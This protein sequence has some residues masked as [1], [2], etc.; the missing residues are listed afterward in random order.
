MFRGDFMYSNWMNENYESLKDLQLNQL[1][2]PGTHDSGTYNLSK[3]KLAPDAEDSIKQIWNLRADGSFGIEDFIHDWAKC[4]NLKFYDQLN[5]GIRYFD[6]RVCWIDN[7]FHTCHSLVG[8]L[9][10]DIISN[11]N[12]FLSE[13]PKE[14]IVVK[15]GFESLSNQQQSEAKNMFNS[16]LDNLYIETSQELLNKTFSRLIELDNRAI[17]DYSNNFISVHWPN[18]DSNDDMLS[19]LKSL[20]WDVSNTTSLFELQLQLTPQPLMYVRSFIQKN[21][22]KLLPLMPTMIEHVILGSLLASLGITSLVSYVKY[23]KECL[24]VPEN[25]NDLANS[26]RSVINNFFNWYLKGQSVNN[27]PIR[28]I[29]NVMICDLFDSIPFVEIAIC[30]NKFRSPD[31]LIP[32]IKQYLDKIK[33]KEA[34][35]Y[36]P[37]EAFK[38]SFQ[39]TLDAILASFALGKFSIIEL[40]GILKEAFNYKVNEMATILFGNG[41]KCEEVANALFSVYGVSW[42]DLAGY[43]YDAGYTYQQVATAF[44]IQHVPINYILEYLVGKKVNPVTIASILEAAGYPISGLEG[45]ICKCV[46]DVSCKCVL[47]ICNCIAD[48]CATK[49]ICGCV[50]DVGCITKHR[51]IKL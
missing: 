5:N 9:I 42:V 30:M 19:K 11:I 40:T 6:L 24:P 29:P 26:S 35:P 13:N 2:L 33:D 27:K 39:C 38:K 47:D 1:V 18:K 20:E 23:L 36:D 51:C 41:C 15:V 50:A 25:I 49:G 45:L 16:I 10:S 8:D 31:T 3:E 7:A 46:L 32:A 4:Q 17:F 37:K 14:I 43:L 34:P 48:I 28:Q 22:C 12:K 21:G 44:Y